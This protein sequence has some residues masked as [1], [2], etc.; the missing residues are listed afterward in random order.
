[1]CS[2]WGKCARTFQ[3]TLPRRERLPCVATGASAHAH[4]NPRS[5]E[6]SDDIQCQKN[7]ACNRFQS[8]LPRRERRTSERNNH[9][10][11]TFQ[12]TLPRRERL[13]SVYMEYLLHAFQSTLPR[14]ERHQSAG[15]KILNRNLFQSTLPRRERHQIRC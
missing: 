11:Y 15:K 4:F 8:T 12:S 2:H 5:R 9:D 3:S 10:E 13:L 6:G 7:T 14:R 1:M